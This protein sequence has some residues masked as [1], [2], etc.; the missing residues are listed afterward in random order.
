MSKKNKCDS[1]YYYIVTEQLIKCEICEF[2]GCVFD[3]DL[4]SAC[5]HFYGEGWRIFDNTKYCPKCAE[6]HQ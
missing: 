2:E 3:I 5:D 6:K 4:S 1:L